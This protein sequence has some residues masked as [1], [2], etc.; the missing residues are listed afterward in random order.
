MARAA[1]RVPP[2][3]DAP[4]APHSLLD[5]VGIVQRPAGAKPVSAAEM[6]KAVELAVAEKYAGSRRGSR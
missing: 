2:T 4:P 5:L 3:I 6:R 1:Q